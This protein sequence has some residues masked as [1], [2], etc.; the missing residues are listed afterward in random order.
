[1]SAP[2]D[3]DRMIAFIDSP[4]GAELVVPFLAD[5]GGDPEEYGV[6]DVAAVTPEQLGMGFKDFLQLSLQRPELTALVASEDVDWA[7][8]VSHLESNLSRFF[9]L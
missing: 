7:R 5:M 9:S 6:D 4:E 8:V 1:L 3:T 2:S